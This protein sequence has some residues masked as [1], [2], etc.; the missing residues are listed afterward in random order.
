VQTIKAK[1]K[2]YTPDDYAFLIKEF[3]VAMTE[4]PKLN[5]DRNKWDI[6]GDWSGTGIIHFVDAGYQGKFAAFADFDCRT[7]KLANYGQ[8][9]ARISFFQKYIYWVLKETSLNQHEKEHWINTHLDAEY[10]E[11]QILSDKC[12]SGHYTGTKLSEVRGDIGERYHKIKDWQNVLD[13]LN[14][15]EIAVSNYERRRQYCTMNY[16][17][18]QSDLTYANSDV[19]M[20]NPQKD[21][22][23]NITQLR[24]NIVFI[25][26]EEILRPH[27]HQHKEIDKFLGSFILSTSPKRQQQLYAK[28]KQSLPDV[29]QVES[30]GSEVTQ[31]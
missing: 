31:S 3:N 25:D 6:E 12:E 15:F 17:F 23:G 7:I 8:P 22:L 5:P 27:P 2:T 20:L 10:I 11:L 29:E 24:Y 14:G 1:R 28:P 18:L 13:N 4:V 21:R 16:K 26:M 9:A 30:P 19:H